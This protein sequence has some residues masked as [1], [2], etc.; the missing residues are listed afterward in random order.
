MLENAELRGQLTREAGEVTAEL[1][2]E[3]PVRQMEQLYGEVLHER[4]H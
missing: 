4:S 3:E 2:M 1:S